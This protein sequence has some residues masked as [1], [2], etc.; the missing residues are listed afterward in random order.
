MKRETVLY[1]SEL[2]FRKTLFKR[3]QSPNPLLTI[4]SLLISTLIVQILDPP[5]M[6]FILVNLKSCYNIVLK[7]IEVFLGTFALKLLYINIYVVGW[8]NAEW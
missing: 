1:S 8:I 2:I 4:L 5:K 7:N 6:Q 3:M